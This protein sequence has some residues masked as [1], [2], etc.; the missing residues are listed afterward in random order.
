MPYLRLLEKLIASVPGAHGAMLLDQEGERVVEAG[1]SDY[2]H[3]LIGAYQGIALQTARASADR[4]RAGEVRR[5]VC[6]YEHGQLILLPLK[7]GYYMLLSVSEHTPLALAL[8][9]AS[10]VRDALDEH[11]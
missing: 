2:R 10:A 5:V 1:A 6:R 9:R 8:E 4:H 3:R 11:M 7:D